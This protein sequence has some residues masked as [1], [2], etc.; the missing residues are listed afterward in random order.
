MPINHNALLR[1]LTIDELLF[2]HNTVSYTVIRK[3]I[4]NKIN[5][6]GEFPIRTLQSDIKRMIDDYGA[7]IQRK[8]SQGG[9]IFL[10]YSRSD[11]RFLQSN[12]LAEDVQQIFVLE[13]FLRTLP[14]LSDYLSEV[15]D[16]LTKIRIM[17]GETFKLQKPVLRF[18]SAINLVQPRHFSEILSAILR[19][20]VIEVVYHPFNM[21]EVVH[22]ILP[23]WI[24]EFNHRWYVF[25][26][27]LESQRF[28]H[29]AF[30]RMKEVIVT[31]KKC[32]ELPVPQEYQDIIGTTLHHGETKTKIH[33]F[34]EKPRANY[35]ITKRVHP[36]LEV[37]KETPEGT[38]FTIEVVPNPEM[39]NYF[40]ELGSDCTVL[41]PEFIVKQIKEKLGKLLN[42]YR[43][44]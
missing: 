19:K 9:D 38:Y 6:E 30:D 29:L 35:V 33:F 44:N 23:Y 15:Q 20:V 7:P 39:F 40:F 17:V 32:N 26:L 3:E 11:Y 16:T 27:H 41:E 14:L 21:Q 2:K 34:V 43:I 5:Y 4:A 13:S 25:G 37:E 31:T 1:L 18:D 8:Q 12:L 42:N 36:S 10:S 28:Y 24:K 22:Q